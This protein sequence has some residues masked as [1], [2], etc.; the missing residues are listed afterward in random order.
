M[1]GWRA[2]D[3]TQKAFISSHRP[4]NAILLDDRGAVP[5]RRQTTAQTAMVVVATTT[6]TT[7][8]SYRHRSA[9]SL[10]DVHDRRLPMEPILH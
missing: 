10:H 4:K 6:T 7:T 1:V 9:A 2:N 5:R 3:G 8:L